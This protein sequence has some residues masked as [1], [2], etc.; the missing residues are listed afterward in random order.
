MKGFNSFNTLK[1]LP[2][3]EN[4]E[5]GVTKS[6]LIRKDRIDR[7]KEIQHISASAIRIVIKWMS[8]RREEEEQRLHIKYLMEEEEQY[9]Y[10][11]RIEKTRFGLRFDE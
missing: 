3:Q 11:L 4:D 2:K 9:N 10:E 1:Y 5:N 7:F 8:I 6:S